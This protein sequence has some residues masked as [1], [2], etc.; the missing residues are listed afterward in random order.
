MPTIS[1]SDLAVNQEIAASAPD[2]LLNVTI[3][4]QNPLA[5]GSYEFQLVVTDDSGNQSN[6]TTVK[7]VIADDTAPTAVI[8]A[9]DRVGFGK[10]FA[11]SGKRSIDI[12]GKLNRFTW[13]LIKAP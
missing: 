2:A 1:S 9:P 11:L 4:S 7:I 3:D 5:T 13:T 8:D 6:P 12:G 10:D